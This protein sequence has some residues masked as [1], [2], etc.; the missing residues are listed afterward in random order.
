MDFANSRGGT[1]RLPRQMEPKEEVNE[2]ANCSLR[3]ELQQLV[4][5]SGSAHHVA[6]TPAMVTWVMFCERR[7]RNCEQI[8]N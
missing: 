8:L 1:I 3:T 7:E 5:L 4:R 6:T 2:R